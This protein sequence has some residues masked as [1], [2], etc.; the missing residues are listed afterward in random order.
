MAGLVWNSFDHILPVFIVGPYR[1]I[2]LINSVINLNR[3]TEKN[4]LESTE[5][6]VGH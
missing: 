6:V 2:N 4:G 1:N 3:R 5:I